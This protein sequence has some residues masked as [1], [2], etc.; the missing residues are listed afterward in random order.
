[1]K[2]WNLGIIGLVM[3]ALTSCE[4]DV[5]LIQDYEPNSFVFGLLDQHADTQY[6]RINRAFLGTLNI[7]DMAS[8]ND[9]INY[10]SGDLSVKIKSTEY[11]QRNGDVQPIISQTEIF[12]LQELT[13]PKDQGFFNNDDYIV[14]YFTNP[15]AQK[16]NRIALDYQL[17]ITNLSSGKVDSANAPIQLIADVS[18]TRP[19]TNLSTASLA[20][21]TTSGNQL[22]SSYEIEWLSSEN[23]VKHEVYARFYYDEITLSNQDTSTYS[24]D[25]FV[26]NEENFGGNSGRRMASSLS[27]INFFREI[28]Q[29]LEVKTGIQR[30]RPRVRFFMIVANQDFSLFIDAT[31][32]SDDINQ[33]RPSYSN[34][35]NGIGIFGARSTHFSNPNYLIDPNNPRFLSFSQESLELLISLPETR[36]L[37]FKQI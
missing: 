24:F 30:I 25:Y 29:Q 21:Y 26:G 7:Q 11:I 32:P 33:N 20:K 22:N 31:G 1:M 18:L 14:Y 8:V 36:D 37:S 35:S 2:K 13:V 5:D 19:N 27:P 28:S 34:M 4:T 17:Y 6:V 23:A 16:E 12:E 3:V 10:G 15:I 9:S